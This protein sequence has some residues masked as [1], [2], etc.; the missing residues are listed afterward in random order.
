ML[1]AVDFRVELDAIELSFVVDNGSDASRRPSGDTEPW[2]DM[3][4]DIAM[5]EEDLLFA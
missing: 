3:D 1:C 2:R 4:D 5:C